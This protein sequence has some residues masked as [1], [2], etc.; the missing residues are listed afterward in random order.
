VDSH[1]TTR[2]GQ[3]ENRTACLVDTGGP[4]PISAGLQNRWIGTNRVSVLDNDLLPRGEAAWSRR[5]HLGGDTGVS[6]DRGEAPAG[7]TIRAVDPNVS[8]QKSH[9]PS[10]LL[11]RLVVVT[12]RLPARQALGEPVRERLLGKVLLLRADGSRALH[13]C[14]CLAPIAVWLSQASR[15]DHD[16]DRPF[17]RWS[18]GTSMMVPND[19]D[20]VEPLSMLG[21]VQHPSA[22][23]KP[24]APAGHRA[25]Q[26]A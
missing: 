14:G 10:P 9:T 2:T 24:V 19:C 17:H 18:T 21:C 15:S 6:N 16:R 23:R 1:A 26:A 5:D 11:D 7:F 8:P 22:A 4:L 12:Y 3:D 13:L 25:R 20:Q